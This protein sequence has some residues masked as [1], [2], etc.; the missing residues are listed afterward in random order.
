MYRF[1]VKKAQFSPSSKKDL[2]STSSTHKVLARGL[3]AGHRI[4]CVYWGPIYLP[5]WYLHNHT[6]N[7]TWPTCCAQ[8]QETE[9]STYNKY[10]LL[11]SQ[12]YEQISIS[13]QSVESLTGSPR[14]TTGEDILVDKMVKQIISLISIINTDNKE[15]HRLLI[16]WKDPKMYR[17][18]Q[19]LW[20]LIEDKL[21]RKLIVQTAENEEE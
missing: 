2:I 15:K 20:V 14:R 4:I 3:S 8:K 9:E 12:F 6:K 1:G 21:S 5:T 7:L 17:L 13:F 18:K 11:F 16:K 10:F 19:L